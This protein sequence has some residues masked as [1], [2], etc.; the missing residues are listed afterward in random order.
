[1]KDYEYCHP[2][3][4][5][6]S[7]KIRG[8]DGHV[9]TCSFILHTRHLY[10]VGGKC[11]VS[12]LPRAQPRQVEL[13]CGKEPRDQARSQTYPCLSDRPHALQLEILLRVCQKRKGPALPVLQAKETAFEPPLKTFFFFFHIKRR[14][15]N[16]TCHK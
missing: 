2:W 7:P 15:T 16:R 5:S 13:D 6:P 1:M 12:W 8:H 14:H 4:L 11:R 3:V 9:L 10:S